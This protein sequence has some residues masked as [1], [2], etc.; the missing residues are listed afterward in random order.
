MNGNLGRM[1][2]SMGFLINDPKLIFC[3]EKA[4]KNEI[5]YTDNV[6]NKVNYL[7]D[8][9]N[10][11]KSNYNLG[12]IRIIIENTIPEH[13]GFGSKTI[14][15]IAIAT[16]YLEIYNK[17]VSLQELA[18]ILKRGGTSGIGVNILDKGGFILNGGRKKKNDLLFKPSSAQ[19]TI[20]IPPVLF[21]KEMMEIPVYIL[22]PNLEGLHGKKEVDF[23]DKICPIKAKSVEKLSRIIISQILP[24]ICENDIE[25]FSEAIN[26]IQYLEWK[27]SEINRYPHQYV[28]FI[29]YLHQKGYG[30]GMS[31]TGPAIYVIGKDLKN[32]YQDINM[33]NIKLKNIIKTSTNNIGIKRL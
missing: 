5:I 32:I 17:K 6:N 28:K 14:T 11:L 21:H 20:E 26:S 27:K 1:N 3:I 23:F 33:Y 15:K 10:F 19:P 18:K 24:A 25:T 2:G 12:N 9:L 16:A 13:L 31:S 4:E 29:K 8:E 30:C 22:I 7:S